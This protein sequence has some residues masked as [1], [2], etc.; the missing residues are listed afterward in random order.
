MILHSQQT[1]I[2]RRL[3]SSSSS[4]SSS[5]SSSESSRP[6]SPDLSPARIAV[7]HDSPRGFS[8]PEL[9]FPSP[10]GADSSFF[11]QDTSSPRHS[12]PSGGEKRSS[13]PSIPSIPE[14]PDEE[15]EG[16][17]FDVNGKIKTTLTDLMNCESVKHDTRMR[18][19]VQTRLMDAQQ[20][21]NNEKRR[22][23]TMGTRTHADAIAAD[24]S[25][26]LSL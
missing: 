21:M 2:R 22:R 15:D 9:T 20:H 23:V 14:D 25:R 3:S 4:V 8:S 12:R 10:L 16:K 5:S 11:A 26:K 24:R 7:Y 17:L 19:W 1:S 13:L 6:S 18:T